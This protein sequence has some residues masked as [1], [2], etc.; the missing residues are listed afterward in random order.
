MLS[1]IPSSQAM[2]EA[3]MP[4]S[5]MAMTRFS[6]SLS[7]LTCRQSEPLARLCSTVRKSPVDRIAGP[8]GHDG[9]HLGQLLDQPFLIEERLPARIPQRFAVGIHMVGRHA[10]HGATRSHLT[11]RTAYAYAIHPGERHVQEQHVG[12]MRVEAAS[13]D[14]RG[15]VTAAPYVET[16]LVTAVEAPQQRLHVLDAQ[17]VVIQHPDS[18]RRPHAHITHGTTLPPPSM[19]P[20]RHI[21]HRMTRQHR[22]MRGLRWFPPHPLDQP[23]R[24]A[25][26]DTDP[27]RSGR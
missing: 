13:M 11:Y 22:S 5:V 12:P 6:D 9:E 20:Y 18:E 4:P 14:G 24:P 8:A 26:A 19:P 10:H 15:H 16:D 25:A 23:C 17:V 7:G 1:A 2:R 27:W 3:G 21:W